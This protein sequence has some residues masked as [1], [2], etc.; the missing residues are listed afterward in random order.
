MLQHTHA[1]GIVSRCSA[2]CGLYT[3]TN[4][5][6]NQKADFQQE[7]S[8]STE[9]EPELVMGRVHP[10]VGLGWVGSRFGNFWWFGLG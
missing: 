9:R 10:W 1:I 3:I 7:R 8:R 5:R 4:N 2:L 6:T